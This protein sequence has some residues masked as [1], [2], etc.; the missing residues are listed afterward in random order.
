MQN[1]TG[2]CWIFLRPLRL[3]VRRLQISFRYAPLPAP[4]GAALR[5]ACGMLSHLHLALTPRLAQQSAAQSPRAVLH[6][7]GY[8]DNGFLFD[9]ILPGAQVK[10][11]VRF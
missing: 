1:P 10:V 6:R 2:A 8:E 3:I 5:A 11:G 9:T 7:D 4:S